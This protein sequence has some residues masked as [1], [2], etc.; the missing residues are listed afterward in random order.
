MTSKRILILITL[1]IMLGLGAYVLLGVNSA[2][3]RDSVVDC[4][5]DYGKNDACRISESGSPTSTE[6]NVEPETWNDNPSCVDLGFSFGFKIEGSSGS[7]YTGTFTFTS[8]DGILTGGAP[9]DADNSVTLTSDGTYL[10]WTSTLPLD[11]VFMKG[12]NGG[13]AYIY[14]PDEAT[15]DT[16][17][18]TPSAGPAL[19]HVEFCYDYELDVTKDANTSLT[20]TYEWTITKGP[21]ANYVG[22]PGDSWLHEYDIAVANTGFTDSD[23]AVDGTITI[24]NNTPF[25]ATI[26]NITDE[27]SDYGIAAVNCEVTFPYTLTAGDTL[28]CTYS[29][30]AAEGATT[31]PF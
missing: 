10:D 4:P 7:D 24:E 9:E 12:G 5:P 28:V 23:W 1:A 18:A 22:F 31:N 20:R 30:A 26:E 25:D 3:A 27:I 19:S 13:N 8:A 2:S 6:L 11:A 21:D 15:G 14:D 29:A 16:D 17:L